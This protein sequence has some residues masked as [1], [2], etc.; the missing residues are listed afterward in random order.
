MDQCGSGLGETRA[1]GYGAQMRF[2]TGGRT[3]LNKEKQALER[4]LF[5]FALR[6]GQH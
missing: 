5:F 2:M 3:T 6:G 1:G 4:C